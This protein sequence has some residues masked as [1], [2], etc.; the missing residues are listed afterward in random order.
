M[1]EF[2]WIGN[3]DQVT[4]DLLCRAKA[5]YNALSEH[6]DGIIEGRI[7]AY[8]RKGFPRVGV[9]AVP[10]RCWEALRHAERAVMDSAAKLGMNAVDRGRLARDLGF[11]SNLRFEANQRAGAALAAEGR[12]IREGRLRGIDGEDAANDA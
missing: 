9:E 5:R 1:E 4:V 7:L 8:P 10:A 12:A 3:A 2:P 6:A 11:A